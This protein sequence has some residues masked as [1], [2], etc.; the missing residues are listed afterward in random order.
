MIQWWPIKQL[1]SYLAVYFNFVASLTIYHGKVRPSSNLNLEVNEV[2]GVTVLNLVDGEINHFLLCRGSVVTNLVWEREG[3]KP[4]FITSI[5]VEDLVMDL[6]E[7][8]TIKQ[9]DLD[10]YTC[11]DTVTRDRKSINITGGI[12]SPACRVI[13]TSIYLA[14]I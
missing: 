6:E 13:A 1:N 8:N 12:F 7:A 2:V 3:R 9:E 10:V 5:N 14:A 4:P 11:R